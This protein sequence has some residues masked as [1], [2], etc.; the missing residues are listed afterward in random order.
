[1]KI[2]TVNQLLV[3]LFFALLMLRKLKK[4]YSTNLNGCLYFLFESIRGLEVNIP[5]QKNS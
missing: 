4:F 3:T 1:M 2:S 5:D